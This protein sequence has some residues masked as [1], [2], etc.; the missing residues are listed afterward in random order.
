MFLDDFPIGL[1][2]LSRG[3]IEAF[4]RFF[5]DLLGAEDGERLRGI[6]F[7]PLIYHEDRGRVSF[8]EGTVSESRFFRIK[9]LDG[10]P[11]WVFASLSITRWQGKLAGLGVIYEVEA[12]RRH[13]RE[14]KQSLERYE[15]ILND[16][17][18]QVAEMDL[19]GNLTFINDAGLKIWNLPRERLLGVNYK[20]Y[21]DEKTANE[22]REI[23]RQVYETGVPIK[24][25]VLDVRDKDGKWRTIE[26]SV[27]LLRD[28]EGRIKGFCNVTRDVSD[29]KRAEESL[30]LHRSRLEAIFRSVKDA[31]I[32]VDSDLRILALNDAT[33]QICN[34][35]SSTVNE[36]FAT[37]FSFCSRACEEVIQRTLYEKK[38]MEEQI[39]SCE[40]RNRPHQVV[41]ISSAP[42]KDATG[43]F[44]GAVMVVRDVTRLRDLERALKERTEFHNIVGKSKRM[45]EIYA[46]LEDLS[47]LETTVLITGES[48][49][50]KELIA[51]ALHYGGKRAQGPFITVNCSALSENLL[52]SELFGHVKG[53]FTGAFRD[54]IGRFEAAQGGTILLDEIGD[55]SPLIQL[56]LLRVLQEKEI[57]RVGDTRARKVDVRVIAS[58]HQDLR[59]KVRKGEFRADL[60]YRLKVVEIH[61]PPLRE[62]LEDLP[63]LVEH[64]REK[65]NRQFGKNIRGLSHDVLRLFMNY[66]WPGNVRELE[67]VIE[68]AFVLCRGNFITPDHLP[69]E[70]RLSQS[71]RA[72][73][74]SL[75]I[76]RRNYEKE[77]I[78][79]AL[80]SAGGN[81]SK[82]ARLLG[83]G[84]RTL[85]R[86]LNLF[87]L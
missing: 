69:S 2:V 25:L 37:S 23:Y 54:K 26:K 34:V 3:R 38:P 85:Y 27:S 43:S 49:T 73:N 52:E 63:L 40:H 30:A 59:A 84:R 51:R 83:I 29:K 6:S 33:R 65:F 70:L 75:V 42:L 76:R 35:D 18:V 22:Y 71:N 47:N 74:P 5:V 67:H 68:H 32:T 28:E 50:G 9:R 13:I 56:K 24:N 14:L 15:T 77:E 64:F 82:A 16:V 58:T 61:L 19:Q 86:K 20:S 78:V 8:R 79:E 45:Q 7:W 81:K 55:I 48:G 57:E 62:R 17:E 12:L 53:S 36:L 87:G 31:I 46:L 1:F 44:T 21:V 41:S 72:F 4:N 66:P 60:Y 10:T 11:I 39:I 80:K